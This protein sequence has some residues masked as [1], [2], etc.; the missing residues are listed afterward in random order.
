MHRGEGVENDDGSRAVIT[1]YR[2]G[3]LLVR[4]DFVIVDEDGEVVDPGRR[5]IALCRCGRSSRRP[6]CDGSHRAVG[7]RAA[8][9]DERRPAASPAPELAPPVCG[10]REPLTCV[11]D[12]TEQEPLTKR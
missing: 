10:D 12:A 8:G 3:P 11:P 4:G 5:T 6:F 1:P 7:F 9:G 2:D